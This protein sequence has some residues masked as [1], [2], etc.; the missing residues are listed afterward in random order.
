MRI[1]NRALPFKKIQIV[2]KALAQNRMRFQSKKESVAAM[3][4]F[5]TITKILRAKKRMIIK[6][7]MLLDTSEAGRDPLTAIARQGQWFR[8][9]SQA[10]LIPFRT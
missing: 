4:F 8:I 7:S 6:R 2:S 3:P 1:A 5:C 10:Q 9:L